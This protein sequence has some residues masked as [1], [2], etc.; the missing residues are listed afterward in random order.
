VEITSLLYQGTGT[1]GTA[2]AAISST[3]TNIN[4]I[5]VQAD[6]SNSGNLFLGSSTVT[7][8][9]ATTGIQLQAGQSAQF[10]VDDLNKVYVV[11]SAAGQTFHYL[12]GGP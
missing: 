12:A 1:V 6:S 9:G 10:V 8:S 2:A 11:G 3:S 4:W 7:N 5:V